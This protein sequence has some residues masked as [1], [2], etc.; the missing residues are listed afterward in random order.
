MRAWRLCRAAF[1][2]L[3]G[4]GAAAYGG[5]W[6][7]PGRPLVYLADTAALAILEVRVHLDLPPDLLPDDYKLVRVDLGDLP[8]ETLTAFP[9][10]PRAFGDGWLDEGR[11][12]LLR[13]PSFI[14]PECDNLL[15]NPRH[16]LAG[17][18]QVI[19]ARPF[20]FDRRL[21]LPF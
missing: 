19:E 4:D 12:P 17:A 14:V 13:V 8:V 21:W 16:G 5:R 11:S 1:A 20:A 2:D 9:D 6:N 3:S 7:S 15:L 18:A 10:D